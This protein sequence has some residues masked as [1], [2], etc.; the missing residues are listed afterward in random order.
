M[1]PKNSTKTNDHLPR[2]APSS[3]S[4][5]PWPPKWA[6]QPAPIPGHFSMTRLHSESETST[7]V[8]KRRLSRN[9]GPTFLPSSVI[10]D[11]SKIDLSRNVRMFLL[12]HNVF[13]IA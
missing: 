9:L 12:L 8:A 7:A 4:S 1:I 13:V 5:P 11:L 6:G 10:E 3:L 2:S